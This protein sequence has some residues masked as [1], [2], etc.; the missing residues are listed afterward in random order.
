MMTGFLKSPAAR[1]LLGPP[2]AALAYNAP[3]LYQGAATVSEL[4]SPASW[5][6]PFAT[7]APTGQRATKE[8][9]VGSG[10]TLA[11]GRMLLNDT[12]NHQDPNTFT[13]VVDTLRLKP[14]ISDGRQAIGKK[15]K[16]QGVLATYR[17]KPQLLADKID[18]SD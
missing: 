17:G 5:T 1:W 4:R 11:S 2:L 9:T 18:F 15:I 16:A 8:F 3:D 7:T 6:M 10:I 14:T 12:P 13:V